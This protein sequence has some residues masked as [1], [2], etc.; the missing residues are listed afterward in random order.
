M[1]HIK[2]RSMLHFLRAGTPTVTVTAVCRATFHLLGVS[3]QPPFVFP[4]NSYHRCGAMF[5]AHRCFVFVSLPLQANYVL[6]ATASPPPAVT[7][8]VLFEP[9]P[10]PV[11]APASLLTTWKRIRDETIPLRPYDV[12][13]S[14]GSRLFIDVTEALYVQ[15]DVVEVGRG[16]ASERRRMTTHLVAGDCWTQ[17]AGGDYPE[18][19]WK[20]RFGG[21]GRGVENEMEEWGVETGGGDGSEMGQNGRTKHN[22]MTSI[23]ASLTP[24]FRNKEESNIYILEVVN[25]TLRT[26]V[27]FGDVEKTVTTMFN[28]ER[29]VIRSRRSRFRRR[30]CRN[31]S[32]CNTSFLHLPSP[33]CGLR[34]LAG[35]R[36]RPTSPKFVVSKTDNFDR[37]PRQQKSNLYI[38]DSAEQL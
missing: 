14:I 31:E 18:C 12:S 7:T 3:R 24:D 9:A 21:S 35:T 15:E 26:A 37:N 22:L 20:H 36:R 34:V 8:R 2:Q 23:D 19:K 1:Q 30:K 33:T 17:V 32:S 27:V 6:N 16:A 4:Y 11:G 29:D 5:M 13:P 28:M 38:R 25:S 10:Q